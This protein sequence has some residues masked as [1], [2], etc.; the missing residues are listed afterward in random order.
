MLWFFG[1]PQK[2]FAKI[3]KISDLEI[4]SDDNVDVMVAFE[5]NLR[6]NLHLDLYARPHEKSI[7][8]VGEDGTIIW[9]PNRIRIGRQ[10]APEWETEE[11]SDDRNDMFVAVAEEFLAILEGRSE[12]TCTIDDGVRVLKLIEAARASSREEKVIMLEQD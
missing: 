7:Q 12:Y 1:M 4:D 6:V 3:E 5:N 9:E 10:M 2:L 11:F 8:F